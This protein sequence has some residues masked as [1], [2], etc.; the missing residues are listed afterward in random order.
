LRAS[1][2]AGTALA[3]GNQLT[4][5]SELLDGNDAALVRI[6]LEHEEQLES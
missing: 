3:P 6:A 5:V 1:F 2:P 4:P